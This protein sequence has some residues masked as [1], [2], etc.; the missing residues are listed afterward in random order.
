MKVCLSEPMFQRLE[1]SLAAMGPDLELVRLQPDGTYEGD[2]AGI[3][4]FCFSVDLA[5]NPDSLA[6]AGGLL[7]SESLEWVQAP[8]AGV[9]H[10]IWA[11]LLDRGVRLTN[12]AGVHAEP[13]AQYVFTYVLNDLRQV[14][15]HRDQQ[16]RRVWETIVSDD[17]TAKTIGIVGM[18]GIGRATARI[19]TAFGMEVLGLRRGPIDDPAVD[20]GFG[21]GGLSE[22]LGRCDYVVLAVPLSDETRGMI[23]AA[24]LAAMKADAVLINVARGDVVD[25]PALISALRSRS[26]RGAVLDVTSEEPLGEDSPLWALDNCLITPHDAGY[27]PL[28]GERLGRLFLEN[29]AAFRS[30]S[31]LR[32]EVTSTT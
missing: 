16:A 31:P 6:E 32:N 15:R 21:P 29:L 10:A 12:A 7:S 1:A 23:D 8:G 11:Q 9:E 25:E 4:V 5:S 20:E 13:I 17:L 27:S 26:I 30:G 19:A 14:D 3:D 22:M 28:A 24:A 2:P 18:G